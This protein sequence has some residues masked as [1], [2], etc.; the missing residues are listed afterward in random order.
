MEDDRYMIIKELKEYIIRPA[1]TQIGMWSASAENLLAGTIMVESG[2]ERLKQVKGPALGLYQ[3]EPNT[4]KD[5]K[6]ELDRPEDRELKANALN[7]CGM[8]DFPFDDALVWNLRYATIIARLI[9]RRDPMALP[10]DDDALGL[11]NT[12]KRVFNTING[13]ADARKSVEVFKRVIDNE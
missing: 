7:A 11:A 5:I 4:H 3:I 10:D 2:G 1:L 9:Y 13:K 12:H 6:R 8:I